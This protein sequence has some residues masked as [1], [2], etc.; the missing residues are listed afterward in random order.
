MAGLLDEL[1]TRLDDGDD[2]D[3]EDDDGDD[4]VGA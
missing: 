3:D 2:P 4:P 1:R